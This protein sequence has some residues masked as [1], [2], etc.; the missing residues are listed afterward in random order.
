[1][2][3]RH[4]ASLRALA[5]LHRAALRRLAAAL[6]AAAFVVLAAGSAARGME[7]D[8]GDP[9]GRGAPALPVKSA[10]PSDDDPVAERFGLDEMTVAAP[11]PVSA[12]DEL[13]RPETILSG[14]EL[15][16]ESRPTLGD[17]LGSRPGVS[18]TYYGPGAS[19]P[20]IRGLD[21]ERV[22]ILQNGVNTI[23][24]SATSVDHAIT[25]EPMNVQRVDVVR[26]PGALLYGA[27]A[28]GGVVD[29]VDGRIPSQ[30]A[31]RPLGGRLLVSGSSVDD[32]PA[33]ALRLEGGGGPLAWQLNG[34]ARRAGDLSI[35]GWARTRALREQDPPPPGGTEPR[36]TLPNSA[37]TTWGGG[38]AL[39]WIGEAGHLGVGPSNYHTE[40]GT[41]ASPDVRIDL[42]STRIDVAGTR[43][44]PLPGIEQ[45]TAK[46]AWSDYEH[47]EFEGRE[48]GTVFRS[49]GY[50]LR[51]DA[52]HAPLRDFTGAFG[53]EIQG[54]TLASSGEEAYLPSMDSR[55][56]SGFLL[57]E[58]PLGPA[59]LQA[60]LRLDHAAVTADASE[61][62]GPADAREFFVPSGSVGATAAPAEGWG[63]VFAASW[64]Q[65][66]PNGQELFANG[67]HVATG[68]YEIGD[69]DLGVER[70]LGLEFTLR[71]TA[72]WITGSI[73]GFYDRFE[74]FITL[75]PTGRVDPSSGLDVYEVEAVPATLAGFEAEATLP[76]LRR[77]PH[78]LRLELQADGVWARERDDDQPL[79]RMPPLR[80]GAGLVYARGGLTARIDVLQVAAQT[81]NPTWQT[82]TP[83]YTMLDLDLAWDLP[84]MFGLP[85]GTNL[86]L[87]AS[88]LLD[89]TA[90]DA[91]SF[92]KDVA[93]LPGI[94]VYGGMGLAF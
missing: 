29:V 66:A 25:I 77:G 42:G 13:A 57:E 81:R 9:P 56:A 35:P 53:I 61:R 18:S 37:I 48:V 88:N 23:D 30:A 45:G 16:I 51:L 69:P 93:P 87:R 83:S 36:G 82:F 5:S 74:N 63:V 24:A 90:R 19:R 68:I 12:I 50:D 85:A 60:A 40:Y 43:R 73:T 33:G 32:S 67:P 31:P 62:F 7:G 59:R 1:M 54:Q 70:A 17:T 46:A 11:P 75:F 55:G 27:S 14:E 41:V 65:R 79:P 34:F 15:R 91:V 10:E 86:F 84:E 49:R 4:R 58:W 6:P 8:P 28:V 52:V 78:A 92:L 80:F 71:R 26:G 47:T 38:G 72:G 22:R 20:V 44:S 3:D 94:G 76:L 39:S 21:G 2:S 89:V 64:L